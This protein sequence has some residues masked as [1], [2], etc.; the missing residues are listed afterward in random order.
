MQL[1][2]LGFVYVVVFLV[3]L[4]PVVVLYVLF[5]T[6]NFFGLEGTWKGVIAGGPLA[7]YVFLYIYTLRHLLKV[8]KLG[9]PLME[10][11]T[12]REAEKLDART[13]NLPIE[14]PKVEGTW[15][16]S[17]AWSYETTNETAAFEE[18]VEIVQ[19]GREITGSITDDSGLQCA[20]RGSIF[21]RMVT[22]HFVSRIESRL[23]CG[24]VSVK[25]SPTGES[26]NGYQI[27][28][29]LELERLVTTPYSLKGP[30]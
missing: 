2:N 12:A 21:A 25:V 9:S 16:G 8:L 23:S 15:V 24:S 5:G 29:D 1:L 17:W 30:Q 4:V 22:F 26:M 13:T 7:A 10:E 18:T 6:L 11:N 20:F 3:C 14:V 28:Y 27:Y 19:Q